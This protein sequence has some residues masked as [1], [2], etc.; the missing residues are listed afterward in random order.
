MGR[1]TRTLRLALSLLLACGLT[2]GC[3]DDSQPR[4]DSRVDDP[5]TASSTIGAAGG[6]ISVAGM[7]VT[8]PAGALTTDTLLTVT[9]G[10][11]AEAALP[12]GLTSTTPLVTLLPHG[13]EFNAPVTVE[14]PVTTSSRGTDTVWF[15]ADDAD[16]E[17]D[18]MATPTVSGT[19]LTFETL[20]FCTVGGCGAQELCSDQ[21]DNDG[22]GLV[23]CGDP[24]CRGISGCPAS[25]TETSCT[26]KEDED[27]DNATDCQDPDCAATCGVLNIP[28]TMTLN[29][30]AA[31]CSEVAAATT[32]YD[33]D[34]P[35]LYDFTGMAACTGSGGTIALGTVPTGSFVA[36]LTLRSSANLPLA[37]LGPST[38]MVSGGVTTNAYQTF[39]LSRGCPAIQISRVY[40]SGGNDAT[41]YKNDF[42]ELHNRT[43]AP[44]SL[45][46]YGLHV[47]SNAGATWHVTDLSALTI[48]A[49]G[50]V[51]VRYAGGA[52]GM[53][54]PYDIE[55]PAT[56]VALP[57]LDGNSTT[58]V[59][60][61]QVTPYADGVCPA[62]GYLDKFGT[63]GQGTDCAEGGGVYAGPGATE[64]FARTSCGDTDDNNADLSLQTLTSARTTT[65]PG[66]VCPPCP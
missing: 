40:V 26:N 21:M 29:G 19:T 38:I 27:R 65:T 36:N 48:A 34:G 54:V 60:A 8:V 17:W 35:G 51:L 18:F 12:D 50:F 9:V 55:G 20:H 49:N 11:T 41:G 47:L 24:N 7:T 61:Q 13:I 14:L 58:I 39:A 59:L 10:A 64:I 23:D 66:V 52:T 46:G 62:T 25:T 16:T 37:M 57:S 15:L 32:T 5:Q 6:T 43:N 56:P 4:P 63:M 2:V 33:V 31:T 1:D 45:A 22:D 28:F 3:G 44:I 53:D 30:A 42:V